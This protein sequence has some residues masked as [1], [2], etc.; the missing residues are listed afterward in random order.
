MAPLSDLTKK[1]LPNEVKWEMKQEET[2]LKLK[3]ALSK[4]PV[5]RLPDLS[6]QFIIQTDASGV[7]LGCV[8]M[9]KYEGVNHP[10]A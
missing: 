1:Q 5:L 8:L 10:V 3:E 4:A 7:G 9:Q 2:F 6:K